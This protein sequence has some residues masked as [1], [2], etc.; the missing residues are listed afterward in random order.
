M[1]YHGKFHAGYSKKKA[2]SPAAGLFSGLW[3]AALCFTVLAASTPAL[4]QSY[5]LAI[6][7]PAFNN[8]GLIPVHYT[9]QGSDRNPPLAFKNIPPHTASL[10]LILEDPDAPGGTF[11]H[12][13]LW[14]ISPKTRGI[15]ERTVPHG[16]EQGF[17]DFGTKG[18]GGPCP[19]PGNAHR[20]IFELFAV[21]TVLHV[22]RTITRQGL[23]KAIDGHI[24][25]HAL[26]TGFYKRK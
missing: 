18:Y 5:N 12:W 6:S 20:Y 25:A 10:V 4:S 2:G 19:P 3:I 15:D 22:N 21:N 23:E 9:C 24:I 7:S 13:L 26:L 14:N 8:N 16:A 11:T 17:N 1:L